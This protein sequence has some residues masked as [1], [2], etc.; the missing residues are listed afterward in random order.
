MWGKD[1]L[2]SM[3]LPEA[4]DGVTVAQ[5]T[6][7]THE[8]REMTPP[9]PVQDAIDRI[10]ALL[11]GEG[12]DLST[13]PLDMTG[14]PPFHRRVYQLART[15]PP[16][17]T[18]SYGELAARLGSPGA[19]RA[20]GQAMRRNPFAV[21]VPCHRVVGAGGRLGGFSAYGGLGTKM[22]LLALEAPPPPPPRSSGAHGAHGAFGAFD[23]DQGVAHL[24]A[25]DPALARLMD[26][27]GPFDLRLTDAP[28]TFAALARAIVYQQ[29]NG[30]SAAAIYGR[31]SAL[32]PQSGAGA[33]LR[34]EDI[35]GSRDEALLGAGLSRAKLLSILDLARHAADGA[36]P[37]LDEARGMEDEVI[38]EELSQVRGVGRWTAEMFLIF[39]LG[40]PDVLP[41][42]DFGVRKGFAITYRNGEMPTPKELMEYG[43]RWRPYR[44]VASW[45]LWQALVLPLEQAKEAPGLPR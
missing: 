8:A 10:A 7:R 9:A 12:S 26:A 14:V 31:L 41:V 39:T 15:I 34:P 22:E 35:L 13:I 32:F 23:V 3:Q 29:L 36:I 17:Q 33:T 30:R 4:N 11:A 19:G 42:G 37:T 5:L 18:R 2:V 28:T 40:R 20:V 27:V 24:G 38:I 25:V 21:V 44:S 45:Y 16:G 6:E 1:G 43:E